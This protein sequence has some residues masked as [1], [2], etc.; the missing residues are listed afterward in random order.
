MWLRFSLNEALPKNGRGKLKVSFAV[1]VTR[2]EY[3]LGLGKS[4]LGLRDCLGDQL[5]DPLS[6]E[7]W[8]DDGSSG[9]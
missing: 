2:H 8:D 1:F 3:H 9:R 5:R 4:Q 7:L 6:G